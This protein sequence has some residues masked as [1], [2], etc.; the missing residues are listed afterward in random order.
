M[1]AFMEVSADDRLNFGKMG[2]GSS[3]QSVTRSSQYGNLDNV[4][5]LCS[6]IMQPL[7]PKALWDSHLKPHRR[8]FSA[9]MPSSFNWVHVL[10]SLGGFGEEEGNFA[11]SCL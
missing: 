8:S 9:M 1:R 10:Q 2:Y 3:V 5:K 11:S 6:A 4:L 7:M